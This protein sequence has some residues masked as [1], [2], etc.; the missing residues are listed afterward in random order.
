MINSDA[1]G[2]LN[3]LDIQSFNES[4]KMKWIQGYLNEENKGKWKLFLDHYLGKYGGK[5]LFRSNLKQQDSTLL[6]LKDP[7]LKEIIQYWTKF[8]YKDDNLDFASTYIWYNSH[9][10]IENRPFFYRSWLSAGIKEIRDLLDNDQNFLSY[11]AFIDKYSI[12]TNYL[13]YHKVISAVAHYEK[14]H[15]TAYHDQSP[16]DSVDTLLSH[17]KV[18]KK[19]Y[20]C[21]INKKASIP[22]RSQGKWL[23]ERDIH[24]NLSIIVN[25]ENTYCLSSLC[26]REL[27]AFQFKFLH[28][29]IAT[30]C[31]K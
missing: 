12:K 28:R 22:S 14:V 25:W 16:K 2:G 5:L 27:R 29:K 21:L 19:I 1:K 9:I 26:T 30:F 13:E 31:T 8:N 15:S 4:L 3:M 17:T 18:S 10:R 24:C 20:E 6:N 23:E 7:F 11:N